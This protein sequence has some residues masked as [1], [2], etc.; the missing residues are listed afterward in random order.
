MEVLLTCFHWLE[1]KTLL[2]I[3][4]ICFAARSG[5]VPAQWIPQGS[6]AGLFA[7]LFG[8]TVLV[9]A[10]PCALGL[11]TPTAVMVGTGVAASYGIL[12]KVICSNNI[13]CNACVTTMRHCRS[14]R[15]AGMFMLHS[16]PVLIACTVSL[17]QMSAQV[18][19]VA[20]MLDALTLLL[21]GADALQRAT[22]VN[23]IIFDKTGTLTEGRPAVSDV[24]LFSS[25]PLA[26][27][28][29]LAVAAEVHSEHPLGQAMVQYAAE[30]LGMGLSGGC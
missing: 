19:V 4:S 28:L 1:S 25:A 29:H 9:I 22:K 6:N 16:S 12:I 13:Q 14:D 27:V 3:E 20:T 21:Q 15:A 8:A 5:A 26:E 24:H 11:A 30:A 7:L 10:C 18:L 23:A 2:C 17:G